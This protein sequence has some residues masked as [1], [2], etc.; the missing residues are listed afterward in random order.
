MTELSHSVLC[1]LLV[2]LSLLYSSNAVCVYLSIMKFKIALQ[3][4][5]S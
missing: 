1:V 5:V 4:T 3:L 2:P